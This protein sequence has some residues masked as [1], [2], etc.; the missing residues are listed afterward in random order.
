MKEIMHCPCCAARISECVFSIE[1]R[2]HFNRVG[3]ASPCEGCG[4]FFWRDKLLV[5]GSPKEI[6][7][8]MVKTN[9]GRRLVLFV[10]GDLPHE[11]DIRSF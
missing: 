2:K 1:D 4:Q 5:G 8:L 10:W 11:K 7:R 3:P 9:S 6:N